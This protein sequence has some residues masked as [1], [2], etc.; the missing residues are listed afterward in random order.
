MSNE[1]IEINFESV[2]GYGY[3]YY[4]VITNKTDR[5]IYIDKGNC[6]RQEG[7]EEAFCYY[8]NTEQITVNAGGGSG[9][10]IGLGSVAGALGVGGVVG[11]LAGG[12]GV[13][14]GTSR[15]ASTTYLEQRVIAIPPHGHKRL[16]EQRTIKT[17]NGSLLNSAQY[18]TLGT[19]EAFPW[20]LPVKR[21][22]VNK[23]GVKVLQEEE[24]P[25]SR[26]YYL[27]YSTEEDFR[28]Y[29]SLQVSLYVR[30]IIGKNIS[31]WVP[32]RCKT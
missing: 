31:M 25:W 12:I 10:S 3:A 8:E 18:E 11:Q 27:T 21:G 22:I 26:T 16:S 32:S 13:G 24:I 23:G 15:S 14:G 9:A 20:I 4:I 19:L 1:D 28:T 6:F 29:S 2:Y 5:P 17:R 30:E 7:N